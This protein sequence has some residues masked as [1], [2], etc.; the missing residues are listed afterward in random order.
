MFKKILLPTDG[1]HASIKAIEKTVQYA[2]ENGSTVVGF[3]VAQV[4]TYFPYA[5]FA[6]EEER[7][8]QSVQKVAEIAGAAGVPFET[9][10]VKG[11]SPREEILKAAELYNCDSIFMAS[12][13]MKGMDRLLLGSVTQKVLLHSTLPVVVLK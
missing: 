5:N 1:S 13:G 10:T 7:S 11:T 6:D 4:Y 2:K 9:H 3:S 12:H 8:V